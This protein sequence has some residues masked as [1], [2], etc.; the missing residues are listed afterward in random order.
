MAMGIAI[1]QRLLWAVFSA[2]FALPFLGRPA[3][4]VQ[5]F[6]ETAFVHQRNS[7][8][9][10][11]Q[12][13]S[14][15]L[16]FLCPPLPNSVK[17]AASNGTSCTVAAGAA[18]PNC[19]PPGGSTP[20][21]PGSGG[22]FCGNCLGDDPVSFGNISNEPHIEFDRSDDTGACAS[23]PASSFGVGTSSA[24]YCNSDVFLCASVGY[25]NDTST[26]VAIDELSFEVFKWSDGANPLDPASTPPL[27]TFFVDAPG[28][29]QA[30]T[31]SDVSGPLGPFCTLWDGSVNIQGEFG[32][33]NGQ[34]GFRV[35][36]K[37]NQIGASGNIV[38][39]QTRAYPS[40]STRDSNNTIV[41]QR[42]IV[43]DVNNIHVV[44]SS[45]SLIG[46][47]TPV[48]GQPF[49]ISYRLSKD[50][51]MFMTINE[52]ASPF[53]LVRSLVPG[54]PRVGEGVPNGSLTNGDSWNGRADN[55]DLLAPGVYLLNL[56]SAVSDS[57]GPDFSTAVVRQI[58]LDPLQITDIRVQPLVEGSTSLAVLDYVLT[59]PATVYVDIYPPGTQF[60][61]SGPGN[62]VVNPLNQVNNALLDDTAAGFEAR[63]PKD[64]RPAL[65]S[66]PAGVGSGI[67]PVKRIVE[68][69]NSRTRVISFWDGRDAD[70]QLLEDGDYVFVIYAALPTQNG[71]PFRANANDR[72]IW[73]S[74]AKSGFLPVIR[75]F[76]GISQIAPASSV[77]GS[78]P[79]VAGLNPF[80]F[81]YSLS[82]EAVVNFKIFDATGQRLV[83]T[84]VANEQRPG[85]FG[86]LERWDEPIGDDGMT[87]SSGTYLAQLTA[88]DPTFRHKVTTTTVLFPVNL[89]RITDV[90]TTPLLN[91][92]SDVAL[93]SYQLS[94]TMSV[95]INIYP[96]GT[97]ITGSTSTWP[98]CGSIA[99]GSCSQIIAPGGGAVSPVHAI[100]G[101][102]A[103][104]LRITEFWDGRD[105]N[106]LMVPDGPYLFTLTAES[107]TTPRHFATDRVIGNI[108]V[109]RGAIIFTNFV[110]EPDVPD[111]FNSSE[112]VTSLPPFTISYSLTRQ[113]SVTIQVLNTVIPPAVVRTVA[114]GAF[115]ENNV[116]LRDVWDGRDEF[117]NFPP[118]GFYLIRAVASD[119]ASQ[120]SSGS[121]AQVTISF[122]PLRIYDVAVTPLRSDTRAASIFYQV[123]EPM[124]VAIKIYKP[125]TSFD[126]VG[127][128]TTPESVSLVK[129]IVG[130]K[131]ARTQIEDVWDGTD[132]RLSL[133][134]DGSYK[135]KIVGSTD[136]NAIDSL[137]GNV[138]N[139]SA[140]SLDRP[141]DE[142]PVVRNAS[143]DPA[144]DFERNTFAYPNPVTGPTATFSIFTPFQ[145]RVI[146]RIY[147]I[148]GDLVIQKDFGEQAPSFSASPV[149]FVWN[150]TN[151]SGRGVARGIYYAVVRVEETFGGKNILQTV[152]KVLIP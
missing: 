117:G 107:T 82:R 45:P 65:G 50:A 30:Q 23:L 124:K 55:G 110:V 143:L 19:T 47:V 62:N 94:Q 118:P 142:I 64:F 34:F 46:N 84:L 36:V 88:A 56:Q 58:G 109:Q 5:V 44:R 75:G 51:T 93:I 18:N 123:S 104:R 101:M 31:N 53:S 48:A 27:R 7:S 16:Q 106:G 96:P 73:T 13:L 151:Q 97:V 28:I 24:N 92:A 116:L 14:G 3:A 138:L 85:N 15:A 87:V 4:A 17:C 108:T 29:I 21:C 33:T 57:Y 80:F 72:R 98:P 140:L 63:P 12:S 133:V 70:G 68:Q 25:S 60:C 76:V 90:Q 32:K 102:R 67:T 95:G 77:V 134:Q 103:G 37:T 91:G 141:L 127:N 6:I 86:N 38:I 11:R 121:T 9:I 2:F 120:L 35:T 150:K 147:N 54:L 81:R 8:C 42:P 122:D 144:G 149:T 20:T 132:L 131:P 49:N 22:G 89:F 112:T 145:A 126:I 129:R 1:R 152:K 83:K 71:Y 61:P 105:V 137:T 136:I 78:S 79:S 135:F 41:S 69:K 100:R 52:S 111:L 130:V 39:S 10:V 119:L 59:E 114:S 26:T 148:A 146:L 128:P 74:Q 139:P 99:P 113:S 125:G 43:V 66:C 115:R 40:G